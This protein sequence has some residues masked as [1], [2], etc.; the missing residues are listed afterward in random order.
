MSYN[1]QEAI[2]R[3]QWGLSSESA[4][5]LCIKKARR[6][7]RSYPM[8]WHLTDQFAFCFH[9]SQYFGFS[10]SP[11]FIDAFC[12]TSEGKALAFWDFAQSCKVSLPA[13]TCKNGC[14][15][16]LFTWI[17]LTWQHKPPPRSFSVQPLS[18]LCMSWDANPGLLPGYPTA[19]WVAASGRHCTVSPVSFFLSH[20]SLPSHQIS[21]ANKAK[22]HLTRPGDQ[23]TS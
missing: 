7:Q 2:L 8:V 1:L 3:V 10:V 16:C 15:T 18:S 17:P 20:L 13:V 4:K 9:W 11:V 14:G 22:L 5:P 23:V 21:C 12:S 6:S 19:F